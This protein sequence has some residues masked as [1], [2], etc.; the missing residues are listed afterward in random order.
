MKNYFLEAG[1]ADTVTLNRYLRFIDYAL[2]N[3]PIDQYTELHH[4]LPKSC[5]PQYITTD[6]NLVRLSAR[7][8]FIAHWMLWRIFKNSELAGAFWAMNHQMSK[9]QKRYNKLNSRSYQR[10]KEQQSANMRSNNPMHDPLVVQKKSGKN[11]HVY[12]KGIV[13]IPT[14]TAEQHAQ[15]SIRMT[16]NNPMHNPEIARQHGDKIRGKVFPK[17]SCPHCGKLVKIGAGLASH[18]RSTH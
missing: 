14:K 18:L 8:H 2:K 16:E 9:G 17:T 5:F 10:L 12:T 3:S 7:Q 15:Q 4:I 13:N 1:C 11:H 6:W